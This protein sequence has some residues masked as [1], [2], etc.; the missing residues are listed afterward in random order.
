M[1]PV[2]PRWMA[3]EP[4][5]ARGDV[6]KK[7]IANQTHWND[8]EVISGAKAQRAWLVARPVMLAVC[9]AFHRAVRT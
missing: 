8:V 5:L 1:F 9:C 3:A 7:Q 6:G 4:Q 2:L